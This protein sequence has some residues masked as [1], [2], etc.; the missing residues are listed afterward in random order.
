MLV[1]MILSKDPVNQGIIVSGRQNSTEAV[2]P[3]YGDRVR[4]LSKPLDPADLGRR[5]AL[6]SG[7]PE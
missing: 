2:D 4:F 5:I 6:A 7:S 1:D 3:Q